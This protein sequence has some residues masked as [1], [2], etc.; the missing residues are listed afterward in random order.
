MWNILRRKR[1]DLVA[2]ERYERDGVSIIADK[3]HFEG[4]PIPMHKYHRA[5][6]AAFQTVRR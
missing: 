4:R 6:I 5:H 2:R 3:L 1:A